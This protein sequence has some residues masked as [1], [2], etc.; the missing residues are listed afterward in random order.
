MVDFGQDR[1]IRQIRL[2]WDQASLLKEVD[3][4][5]ARGK[6]WPIKTGKEQS[7]L[8]AAGAKST[9]DS[10]AAPTIGKDAG[11]D[12]AV[13]NGEH[14]KKSKDPYASLSLFTEAEKEPE[15]PRPTSSSKQLSGR[16]PTRDYN[17]LFMGGDSET[18]QSASSRGQS[19]AGGPQSAERPSPR[20]T[21]PSKNYQP[22]RL[23][24]ENGGPQDR[25][26]NGLD[27]HI[28]KPHSKRY[29]HF[30][31]G[32]GGDGNGKPK[33]AG[34]PIKSKMPKH[35][36]QWDFEDFVTP[37]KPSHKVRGQDVRHFG[38]SDDEVADTPAQPKRVQ[39]GRRDVET[40]F[41]FKDD[42]TPQ[43]QKKRQGAHAKGTA[44][45]Q[46]LGLYQNNAYNEEGT[47]T[48]PA[49]TSL[50]LGNVTNMNLNNH[51]K[52]FSNHFS[53]ADESPK[54]SNDKATGNDRKK[55]MAADRRAAVKMMNSEWDQ[56]GED[57]EDNDT[58]VASN[59]NGQNSRPTSKDESVDNEN[60]NPNNSKRSS[61]STQSRGY[62]PVGANLTRHFHFGDDDPDDDPYQ[63]K[64]DESRRHGGHQR[65]QSQKSVVSGTGDE[66]TSPRKTG[67]QQHQRHQS[68]ASTATTNNPSKSFWDF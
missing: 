54:S 22:S 39:H 2:H 67:Q 49:K 13:T 4:I 25:K 5:G 63:A 65:T 48:S 61:V 58:M 23:F 46:G 27:E 59:K 38:W 51:R 11:A 68:R 21:A 53:M 64:K 18:P 34:S 28:V 40:H 57:D 14:K 55:P 42:S 12:V 9:S 31:F 26:E 45:N 36:S 62:K 16:P 43:A 30:D 50:P 33:S 66:N 29:D 19:F 6:N 56:Y 37:E 17:D 10:E 60:T 1:Q 32:D 44:S 20:K 24:G 3:V 35:L 15:T 47:P 52:N 8:V 7:S 41:E